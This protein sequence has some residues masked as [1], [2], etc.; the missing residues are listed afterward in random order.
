MVWQYTSISKIWVL[1]LKRIFKCTHLVVYLNWS[2][3]WCFAYSVSFH[4]L[5]GNFYR[6]I[7]EVQCCLCI[8]LFNVFLCKLKKRIYREKRFLEHFC[9]ENVLVHS[10]FTFLYGL[11]YSPFNQLWLVI[12]CS[13]NLALAYFCRKNVI[14]FNVPISNDR[15]QYTR[16]YISLSFVNVFNLC[17]QNY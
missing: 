16:D 3:S 1:L 2:D 5:L 7:K 8:W 4:D 15:K 10:K 14:Y 9:S 13:I 12:I 17:T 11:K 6:N